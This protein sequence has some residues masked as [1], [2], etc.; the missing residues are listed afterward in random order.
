MDIIRLMRAD[1]LKVKNTSYY[2]IHALVPVIAAIMLVIYYGTKPDDGVGSAI[3]FLETISIGFPLVI[4]V[5]CS[6]VIEKEA[7]AGRF[8]EMLSSKNGKFE[9]LL[10]KLL[11]LVSCGFVSFYLSALIFYTGLKYVYNK[12]TISLGLF[13]KVSLIVFA[14]MVFFYIFHLWISLSFGIGASIGIGVFESLFATLLDTGLGEGIW[15]YIPCGFGSRLVKS[16]FLINYPSKYTAKLNL[17]S[18][19]SVNNT[20]VLNCFI[21]TIVVGIL[22]VIWFNYFEGREEA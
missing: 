7:A 6:L 12:E 11:V 4:G 1:F 18:I 8:K 22:L 19:I 2:Y 17:S 13:M 3:G 21:F 14:T 20:A 5:V 15:Q 9:C 16:Y 10:S